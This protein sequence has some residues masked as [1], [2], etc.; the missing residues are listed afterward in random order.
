MRNV[1][2]FVITLCV[3]LILT[4][5]GCTANNSTHSAGVG[6]Q[7]NQN[8]EAEVSPE[9]VAENHFK[10]ILYEDYETLLACL[11]VEKNEK[12]TDLF[13]TE[14]PEEI[15]AER[16]KLS[17]SGF[18]YEEFTGSDKEIAMAS[19]SE[20]WLSKDLDFVYAFS[21]I[22]EIGRVIFTMSY[23]EEHT[24]QWIC[25]VKTKDGWFTASIDLY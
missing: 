22:E 19:I 6:N 15:K 11:G 4:L 5:S 7:S 1:A 2:V 20:D 25:V 24:E 23:Q 13:Q 10:S 16:D 8:Q 3:G 14:I 21:D 18:K 9:Q 12:S 17:L